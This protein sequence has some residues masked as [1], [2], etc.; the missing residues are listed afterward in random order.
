MIC[1]YIIQ[2]NNMSNQP[3]Q[4]YFKKIILDLESVFSI[5]GTRKMIF[6]SHIIKN[7]LD[8]F[9]SLIKEILNF[10]LNI[11]NKT[12]YAKLLKIAKSFKYREK[13]FDYFRNKILN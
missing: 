11:E 8:D 7:C 5:I 9:I 3:D 6:Y 2:L 4:Y 12:R 1:A 13:E 10:S